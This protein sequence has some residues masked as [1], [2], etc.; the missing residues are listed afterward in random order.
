MIIKI[1]EPQITPYP[2]L[3]GLMR[4]ESCS[5][6]FELEEDRSSF[7]QYF[8][9]LTEPYLLKN[10]DKAEYLVKTEIYR[11]LSYY[12]E[13]GTLIRMPSKVKTERR[14]ITKSSPAHWDRPIEVLS[15][16][17]SFEE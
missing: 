10:A 1:L 8:N 15:L 4:I 6:Y 14:F 2:E 12:Y 16:F 11:T 5:L 13:C 7:W 9:K 3:K 17:I